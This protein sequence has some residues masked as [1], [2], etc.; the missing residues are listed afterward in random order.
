[1]RNYATINENK[2]NIRFKSFW[3]KLDELDD[4]DIFKEYIISNVEVR[5]VQEIL[6]LMKYNKDEYAMLGNQFSFIYNDYNDLD[7]F[8]NLKMLLHLG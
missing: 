8:V 5:V 3:L 6:V 2:K 4:L 1:M 7:S